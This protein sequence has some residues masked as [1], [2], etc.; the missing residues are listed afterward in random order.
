MH[1]NSL[2]IMKKFVI[3]Y[4]TD[5]VEKELKILDLGSC[6]VFG[7]GQE[8]LGSYRQF[9]TNKKW[10]YKGADI[11]KGNNVDIVMEDGYKFPFS[12]NKF[13]LVISGQT[14]EHIEYPWVWFKEIKRV[15]KKGGICCIIAPFRSKEHK[16]P[17]D[18]FRYYP[19]GMKAL[20]K[21]SELEIV[22]TET[23]GH[24]TY[25]IAKKER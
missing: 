16:S 17:V 14:L 25:L 23:D 15:L 20:A 3:E 8:K 9:F 21:W 6:I 2:K 13:D 18:T 11:I 22:K 24:D 7:S 1:L 4:L 12:N 19:D 10:H 5:K